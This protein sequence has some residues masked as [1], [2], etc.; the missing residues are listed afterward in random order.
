[1]LDKIIVTCVVRSRY[2]IGGGPE[3]GMARRFGKHV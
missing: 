1:M 2:G 3:E